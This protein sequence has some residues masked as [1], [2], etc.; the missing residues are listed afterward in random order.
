MCAGPLAAARS[1]EAAANVSE[2]F[3]ATRSR[4]VR[5]HALSLFFSLSL[6]NSLSITYK[7][8]H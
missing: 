8:V 4:A 6:I 1:R 5:S 2:L 7:L 3:S